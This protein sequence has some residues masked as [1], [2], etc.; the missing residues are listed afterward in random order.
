MNSLGY[1]PAWPE[2]LKELSRR[3]YRAACR[4][5]NL[6][7]ALDRIAPNEFDAVMDQLETARRELYNTSAEFMRVKWRWDFD[8]LKKR[9]DNSAGGADGTAAE[10]A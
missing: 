7:A 6:E 5:R 9:M 4:V 3:N 2:E 10:K 8:D 1:C